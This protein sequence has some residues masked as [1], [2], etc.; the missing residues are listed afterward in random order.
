LAR[1]FFSSQVGSL[2]LIRSNLLTDSTKQIFHHL[3]FMLQ[4]RKDLANIIFPFSFFFYPCPYPLI[5]TNISLAIFRKMFG[6]HLGKA[7][8]FCPGL[9]GLSMAYMIGGFIF[10]R[11]LLNKKA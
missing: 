10:I 5:K 11:W 2:P 1:P 3:Q 6:K 8:N 7:G 9:N 4:L